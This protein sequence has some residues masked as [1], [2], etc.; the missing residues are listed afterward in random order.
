MK[1]LV[2][3]SRI[4][5]WSKSSS[6]C[7]ISSGRLGCN[8]TWARCVLLSRC[9]WP[10][11]TPTACLSMLSTHLCRHLAHLF[12]PF[13]FYLKNDFHYCIISFDVIEI[14]LPSCCSYHY[15]CFEFHL[16][17]LFCFFFKP[18][19]VSHHSECPHLK[20]LLFFFSI[21]LFHI[22]PSV[23]LRT[24]TYTQYLTIHSFNCRAVRFGW[25]L[26]L[27]TISSSRSFL[28]FC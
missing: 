11:W 28:F 15:F 26:F 8:E 25:K 5:S 2:R 7:A 18:G 24:E 10:N 13:N 23:P 6:S 3:R 27:F 19:S 12:F 16:V 21:F 14:I 22:P 17:Y 1:E 20:D 4:H 9:P